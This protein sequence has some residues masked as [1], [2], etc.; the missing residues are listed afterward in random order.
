[1]K[2]WTIKEL[3]KTSSI[4]FAIWALIDRKSMLTNPYTPLWAKISKTIN[5]LEDL[6]KTVAR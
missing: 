6:K 5:F 3:N 1:M 2:R 4:D